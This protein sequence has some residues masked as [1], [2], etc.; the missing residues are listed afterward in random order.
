MEESPRTQTRFK[1]FL[2]ALLRVPKA[3]IDKLEAER[4]KKPKRKAKKPA[5]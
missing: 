4:L 2:T 5:A 3:E 1:D